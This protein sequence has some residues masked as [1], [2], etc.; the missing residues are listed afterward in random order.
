MVEDSLIEQIENNCYY[1]AAKGLSLTQEEYLVYG[2]AQLWTP[3]RLRRAI[4]MGNEEQ[5]CRTAKQNIYTNL[6]QLGFLDK[7]KE[8]QHISN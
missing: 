8:I 7:I 4:F 5:F 2:I 1:K 6:N 3:E